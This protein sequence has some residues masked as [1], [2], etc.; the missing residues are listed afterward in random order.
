MIWI[1]LTT[2]FCEYQSSQLFRKYKYKKRNQEMSEYYCFPKYLSLYSSTKPKHFIPLDITKTVGSKH[3]FAFVLFVLFCFISLC[4]WLLV[5]QHSDR[6]ERTVWVRL[7]TADKG[8]AEMWHRLKKTKLKLKTF[9][10]M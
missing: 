10:Q 8:T 2:Y 7:R 4:V 3:S 6:K 1:P 9:T 5:T